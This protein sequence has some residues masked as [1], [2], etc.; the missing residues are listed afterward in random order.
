SLAAVR[1]GTV[2]TTH[3]PVPAG[4]DRFPRE[5]IASYFGPGT[6]WSSLPVERI[7]ALGA[8]PDG[9]DPQLFNMAYMGLRLGQRANGV[10]ILHGE[11]SRGM[12]AGLWP[13]FEESEVPI[14]SVTNGVHAPT[15][16]SREMQEL[17]GRELSLD[18][19]D[20]E[21]GWTRVDQIDGAQ[22]WSTRADL[23][24]K[25]VAQ[26][27]S[28]LRQSWVQRGATDAELGWIQTAFDPEVLTIGFARRVPSYKRLTLM[29]RDRERL[30]A[31]LLDPDRPIQIVIAGKAH[32]ADDGG[33]ALVQQI[34]RFTDDPKVRHRIA[35]LP[36][37]DIG[38][39]R[40][41]MPGVD[42]WL[43][44]P[45]RP[46]EASGTSGMKVALNGGLNLSILDGWWDEMFDGANGWAI[47]SA[48]G[49]DDPDRR[50]ELESNALYDLIE[51]N[52]R[53]RFYERGADGLPPRWLEMVR[54][55]LKSLGPQV[56]ASRM[57][58]D[59][60]NQ[61]YT[62]AAVSS[63]AM[64]ADSYAA[65]KDL[66]AWRAVLGTKWSSVRVGH[67]ETIGES[68]NP[69]VGNVLG[70]RASV[71][72]GGLEVSDVTVQVVFGRAD[73]Y[74]LLHDIATAVLSPVGV[75]EDGLHRFEGSVP[76]GRTGSFGYSVRVLPSHPS[77]VNPA[78]LGLVVNA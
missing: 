34:V 32:P 4:I 25:L 51:N 41:M 6:E 37:Y 29:L 68:D 65:A 70:V 24:T 67:V 46:L 2:F 39:A 69:E 17:L 73:D 74:D 8:E 15:W 44:N 14:A 56:L 58:R 50:D 3:T 63:R 45:I 49:V 43:N 10:S 64:L 59:Y 11:V 54:D 35:F 40:D 47:P 42:V 20:D 7:L 5:L 38:M 12:F 1:A 78:E 31:M 13:G 23:R 48:D 71:D 16:V 52:V 28:R 76:L 72:L 33:K 57:V 53:A 60:V 36:D 21:Q 18:M 61:L 22:I 26:I 66:A 55:D 9:G 19:A 77:L 75:G 30:T 27:R 62:P